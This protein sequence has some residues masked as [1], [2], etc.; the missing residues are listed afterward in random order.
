MAKPSPFEFFETLYSGPSRP[1]H[2]ALYSTTLRRGNRHSDWCPNL[3]HA[4]RL[5]AK[6]RTTRRTRFGVALQSPGRALA[7][8]RKRRSRATRGRI[9]GC[10]ASV[11]AL[12][13]LW[14]EIHYDRLT[15]RTPAGS[16]AL[17]LPPGRSQALELLP[18]VELPPSIVL[19]WPGT[20]VALWLLD[21]LWA[22]DLEKETA[23]DKAEARELLRRLRGTV[24]AA[25]T[26]RGWLLD[27]GS[28]DLAAAFPVPDSPTGRTSRGPRAE[29]LHFPLVS[30]GAHYR[31]RDFESL[32]EPP[33]DESPA[34][35]P[36]L[37]RAARL[38]LYQRF[39]FRSIAG[40]CGWIC[41][42]HADQAIL[43]ED[44]RENAVELLSW[45]EAPGAD[46]LQLI[47]ELCRD[48]PHVDRAII[49]RLL[50]GET[51]A[52]DPITCRRI[53][54]SPGVVD[55][56][57]SKCPH[58]GRIRTP[59]ELAVEAAAVERT[60][61]RIAEIA[62][63]RLPDPAPAANPREISEVAPGAPVDRPR[64]LITER[65]HEVNDQ[66]LA[67]LGAAGALFEHGGRIVEV[68]PGAGA[69]PLREARL[70]ELLSRHCAFL[71][72]TP[73]GRL[74]AV[75]PPRWT[76]RGLLS[77]P[78][79]PQ[80]PR[81]EET[82]GAAPNHVGA[83]QRGGPPAEAAALRG[84][85]PAEDAAARTSGAQPGRAH[86]PAPT[87]SVPVPDGPTADTDLIAALEP[88]LAALGGA[89]TARAIAGALAADPGRYPELAAACR[90]LFP[91]LPP[92][93][94]DL[95]A[96]LGYRLRPL[97]DRP[98]GGRVLVEARRHREGIAWSVRPASEPEP[99]DRA[100]PARLRRDVS[101][102]R[103]RR[104]LTPSTDPQPKEEASP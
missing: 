53:G 90:R 93:D 56:F 94:P 25:A 8:A 68:I 43:P 35:H 85:P 27:G 59:V 64:I 74:R 12:P 55:R 38:E 78:S 40:G 66:A 82:E 45:C 6:Y 76:V 104:D 13:A 16:G 14:V 37:E 52:A 88:I 32:P 79:W 70:R 46:R 5:C 98:L 19:S 81:L 26:E 100:S 20:V 10:D 1:G 49:E 92:G 67:A 44:E 65:E 102:A 72:V 80:L 73:G 23:T 30:G 51:P 2:V 3:R 24:A 71:T 48:R 28:P 97:K 87:R 63:P 61:K 54:A 7:I 77:R 17:S 84:G 91:E 11:T 62:V 42:C 101:P 99:A 31:R 29:L 41:H 58:Y 22:F 34:W 39:D 21:R 18:A 103:L 60:E 83:A 9:R 89:A 36:T 69:V 75:H 96:A 4:D 86:G 15:P 57:C 95:P 33:A 50:S 47:R